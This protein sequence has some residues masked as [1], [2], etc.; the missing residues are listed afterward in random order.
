KNEMI[1][2]FIKPGLEDLAVSRTSFDWGVRVP[3][4]P[5][6][7]VYVWIDALVNYISSLGYLS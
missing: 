6:H 3:S 1:N 7:V 5:K 4:N 2:N